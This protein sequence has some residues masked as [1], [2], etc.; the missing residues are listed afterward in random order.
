[1]RHNLLHLAQV[2][3]QTDDRDR[4]KEERTLSCRENYLWPPPEILRNF[5]AE[6]TVTGKFDVSL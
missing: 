5:S 3:C 2:S 6:N 4:N 1:M